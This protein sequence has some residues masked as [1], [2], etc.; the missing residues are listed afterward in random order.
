M[1]RT[2][3]NGSRAKVGADKNGATGTVK[4]EDAVRIILRHMGEDPEREGLKR[5]PARVAKAYEFLTS[6][7]AKDPKEA[8]NVAASCS[9]PCHAAMGNEIPDD[10]PARS[11]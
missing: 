4:L 6:G 10:S 9:A 8:I 2:H 5:T 11:T 7:Y 3:S 1:N